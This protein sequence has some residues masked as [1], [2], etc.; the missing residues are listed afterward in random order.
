MGGVKLK[1]QKVKS[2][3]IIKFLELNAKVFYINDFRPKNMCIYI[4]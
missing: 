3:K 1:L 2:Y 4:Y